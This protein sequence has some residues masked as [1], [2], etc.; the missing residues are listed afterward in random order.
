MWGN[1]SIFLVVVVEGRCVNTVFRSHIEGSL[2][3]LECVLG[4]GMS[5]LVWVQHQGHV[6]ESLDTTHALGL[7]QT[8]N[9]ILVGRTQCPIHQSNCLNGLF[10]C[11]A[12]KV[13]ESIS[14]GLYLIK[15][16]LI[17]LWDGI[18]CTSACTSRLLEET[19]LLAP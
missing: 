7:L 5:I 12:S 9:Q 4:E 6:L 1:T 17:G 8:D 2:K 11:V 10:V 18:G 13:V 3:L 14:S 16:A 15:I 19:F